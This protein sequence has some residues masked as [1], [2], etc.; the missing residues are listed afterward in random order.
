[1]LTPIFR[2]PYVYTGT[3]G[4][5]ALYS[6]YTTA[7]DESFYGYDG[8]DF[9]DGGLGADRMVGGTGH[10][11]YIV[12]NAGDVVIENANE[13]FDTVRVSFS[14]AIPLNVERLEL[15]GTAAINATGS[16]LDDRL[17]G[18]VSSNILWGGAGNDILD[19]RVGTDTMIGGTG[20]DTYYVD[21][22]GDVVVEYANEGTDWVATTISY[23]LGHNLENLSLLGTGAMNLT[24]NELDNA[25]HGNGY[26][27]VL[28]GGLGNDRLYAGNGDDQLWGGDGND[29]LDGDFGVDAMSGGAGNDTYH[30]DNSADVVTEA[31]GQ[32]TDRVQTSATY[33]LATGSEV[34]ILETTDATAMTA[35]DLVGNAFDQTITGNNGTNTIVG[36]LGLDVMTGGASGDVFVWT[37]TA[38]SGVAGAEADVVTDFNGPLGDLLAVN[39]IDADVTV[40][41]NQA[42][43]F[44]G[45]APITGAG[46][47]SYF[48]TATDTYILLSTDADVFQEMTIH[49]A[50]V[51]AVQAS[52]LVL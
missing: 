27:N 1:M 20:H 23:T 52:W 16:S 3:S 48:T 17:Y 45:T 2:S 7:V 37:S 5:D 10:D 43:S 46:Q 36:G 49:L 24:G 12:D 30:V 4:D 19:G 28:S 51:H 32:G 11:T 29:F 40:G 15:T 50:G 41:G 38:E 34:E 18:N 22:A 47:I 39:L 6:R 25:L 44:I 35:L 9:I 21:N 33:S 31:V 14:Y 26:T 42:F 8:N 13:G